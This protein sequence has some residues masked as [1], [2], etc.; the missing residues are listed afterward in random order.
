M[1]H[2]IVDRPSPVKSAYRHVGID[3]FPVDDKTV[4]QDLAADLSEMVGSR[5]RR[6][7]NDQTIH[8]VK[9]EINDLAGMQ[10]TAR[11]KIRRMHY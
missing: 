3:G 6:I 8:R 1:K 10:E 4:S 2:R 11:S 5:V 7:Q 9:S